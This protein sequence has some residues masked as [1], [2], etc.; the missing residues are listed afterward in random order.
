MENM[1]FIHKRSLLLLGSA[2]PLWQYT[3]S[4]LERTGGVYHR[5]LERNRR[6]HD[7]VPFG[8]PVEHADVFGKRK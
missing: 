3:H 2:T 8:K 6:I 1:A 7:E 5:Q 4:V